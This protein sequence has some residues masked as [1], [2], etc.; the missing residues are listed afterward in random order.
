MKNEVTA[1]VEKQ[2]NSIKGLA[3]ESAFSLEEGNWDNGIKGL[4]ACLAMLRVN[5][6]LW[7]LLGKERDFNNLVRTVDNIQWME[8]QK[9][10][11]T[12]KTKRE[13]L[14]EL[15]RICKAYYLPINPARPVPFA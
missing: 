11:P 3:V 15:Y 9:L 13:Q 12:A 2:Y 6:E 10:R 8:E 5:R 14:G 4:Q 7:V 1:I